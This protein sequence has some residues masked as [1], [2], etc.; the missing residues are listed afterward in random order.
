VLSKSQKKIPATVSFVDIAGLVRGASEG[1]GL[2]NHFLSHIREVDALAHVV[3]IFDD[4]HITHVHGAI[5]PFSDI[6]VINLE[7]ILA[8]MQTVSKGLHSRERDMKKGE[9]EVKEEYD[10]LRSAQEI[11]EGGHPL[12]HGLKNKKIT[13]EQGLLL[14]KMNLLTIKPFLYVLNK[15]AGGYNFD[16]QSDERWHILQN[17]F[18]ETNAKYVCVDA[19]VERELHDL[20]SEERMIF[21][22]EY[23]ILEDG[24]NDLIKKGY[25]MLNLITFFTTGETETHAWTILQGSS[26]PEAGRAIHSDFC[27]R[28]IRAEVVSSEDL[29]KEGSYSSLKEKGLVRTE[30]K[31][32]I[33]KD[34]DVVEFRI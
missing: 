17:F 33:V 29:L 34:G 9:K 19:L 5:D 31:E 14:K 11:L 7:L 32:Y 27:D 23:G 15:K 6:E 24:V 16:E 28:F 10:A 30:G 4:T 22:R 12:F 21:R 18:Q 1:E 20:P 8:D 2:G 25:E 26:A 3:R 13:K